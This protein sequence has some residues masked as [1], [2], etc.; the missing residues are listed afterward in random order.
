MKKL[1]IHLYFG[2]FF[3]VNI[4]F[5]QEICNNGIDDDQ[6]GFV[7]LN[8]TDCDC[9]QEINII[10]NGDF[11]E[12]KLIPGTTQ[13][14]Y[15]NQSGQASKF[16]SWLNAVNSWDIQNANADAYHSN[17][18][19]PLQHNFPSGWAGA[20]LEY[21]LKF[22]ENTIDGISSSQNFFYKEYLANN[23]TESLLP[24]NTYVFS[25]Y[26]YRD[27]FNNNFSWPQLKFGLWGK[28]E[29]AFAY[30]IDY[31]TC[32][33]VNSTYEKLLTLPYEPQ[34][35]WVKLSGKLSVNREINGILIGIDCGIPSSYYQF[36][37]SK[38]IAIDKVSIQKISEDFEIETTSPA[39][40]D[41]MYLHTDFSENFIPTRYQWYK[42]GI[43]MPG[44]NSASLYLSADAEEAYYSVRAE[45]NIE[46]RNST[47]YPYFK[48]E[49]RLNYELIVDDV[50]NSVRMNILWN[51]DNLQFSLNNIHYT[52][53][54][55]FNNVA[56][57]ENVI[58]VKNLAGCVVTE[59]PFVIFQI[60]DVITPN[61]DGMND[62]WDIK[63]IQHYPGSEIIL[64]DRYGIEKTRFVI[65]ENA[66]EFRWNSQINGKPVPSGTYNYIIVV[67]DGRKILGR[68]TVK[69]HK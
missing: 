25:I 24:G 45:N 48:P 41:G 38:I 49:L 26:V 28:T 17:Y 15:P 13:Y 51:P 52:S 50:H 57:G 34:N 69:R 4:L 8:D 27:N 68:L 36:T 32:P 65:G 21:D 46:C 2:L 35:N 1:K 29:N 53:I 61:Q 19:N 37:G 30:E 58:Y 55:I 59:I 67:N 18:F 11:E 12:F 31:A 9:I 64:Y 16:E 66:N 20:G 39:C 44:Q 14:D 60:Y 7:D 47:D 6:D 56:L 43:A 40:M 54:P 3:C 10:P 63:G 42:N 5:G 23:L 22:F 33:E 62:T